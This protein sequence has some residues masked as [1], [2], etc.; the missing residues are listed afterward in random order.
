M[1]VILAKSHFNNFVENL[2]QKSYVR[3][4]QQFSEYQNQLMDD[5]LYVTKKNSQSESKANFKQE[6]LKSTSWDGFKRMKD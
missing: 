6:F 4:P 1:K 2:I 3:K 5:L